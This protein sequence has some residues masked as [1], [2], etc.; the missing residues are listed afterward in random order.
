MTWRNI[1]GFRKG[2]F[3]SPLTLHLMLLSRLSLLPSLSLKASSVFVR[4]LATK[5]YT[6]SH[7]WLL[8]DNG[9]ATIGIT[10]H[11]QEELGDIVYVD[12]PSVGDSFD[13]ADTIASVE[14]VKTTGDITIPVAC[15]V[16]EVNEALQENPLLVNQSPEDE[17]WIVK[18]K[19]TSE[20]DLGDLMDET[21]YKKFLAQ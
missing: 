2:T 12:L 13:Q 18:V 14:S 11:A 9:I 4:S 1:Q 5:R 20:G 3:L 15:E 21:S 16:A 19:F 10:N 17:G 7:E 6:A 8:E